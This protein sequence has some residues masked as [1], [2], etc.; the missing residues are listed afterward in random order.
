MWHGYLGWTPR[1]RYSSSFV[2][3]SSWLPAP[4]IAGQAVWPLAGRRGCSWSGRPHWPQQSGPSA[5]WCSGAGRGP[6]GAGRCP[7]L[8]GLQGGRHLAGA[9]VINKGEGT[10]SWFRLTAG[11]AHFP[12]VW[13]SFWSTP[14]HYSSTPLLFWSHF[15][16]FG[17]TTPT[18]SR[19]LF[20]G[21]TS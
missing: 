1:L 3:D 9:R 21:E 15:V 20:L 14:I 10:G 12:L 13:G 5:G 2:R 4:A 6:A 16:Q 11:P 19:H 18:L 8:R 7:G 17:V